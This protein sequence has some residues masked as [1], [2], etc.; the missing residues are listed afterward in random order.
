MPRKKVSEVQT[1][2][3]S[4]ARITCPACKSEISGDGATLH[5]LS[6][7]LEELIETAGDVDKLEKALGEMEAKLTAARA[8]L[9][10]VK[11]EA[12]P[13]PEAAKNES[14]EQK[15]GD[16]RDGKKSSSWW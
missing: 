8:E 4:P 16:G 7:Y 3:N 15:V 14:V 2:G 9:Q 11:E 6:K 1:A 13:K 5:T 12:K 10:K